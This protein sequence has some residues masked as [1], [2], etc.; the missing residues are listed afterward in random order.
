MADIFELF[1]GLRDSKDFEATSPATGEYNCIAWA[2]QDMRRFWW[3]TYPG[4]WP[5]SAP[6]EETLEA[7]DAAYASL[8]YE[9]CASGDLEESFQKIALYIKEGKPQ[10]AA[11][12]LPTG[13]WT[14]KLGKSIDIQH[15]L[16]DLEG[17][18]YGQVVR[19]YRRMRPR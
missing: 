12:Q 2:A 10:H 11:R 4:F 8:G 9:V 17:K 16:K 15:G 7:F 18:L 13:R 1:P 5:E 3:P 14:S 6:R 19:F